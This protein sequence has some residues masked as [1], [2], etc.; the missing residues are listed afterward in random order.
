MTPEA[1][2]VAVVAVLGAWALHVALLFAVRP[3]DLCSGRSGGPSD[4]EAVDRI[5]RPSL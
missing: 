5:R 2:G 3:R 1:V 4:E